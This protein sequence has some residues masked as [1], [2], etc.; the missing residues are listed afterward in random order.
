MLLTT[1]LS[2]D[3]KDSVLQTQTDETKR[4]FLHTGLSKET[5]SALLHSEP[6]SSLQFLVPVHVDGLQLLSTNIPCKSCTR[7]HFCSAVALWVTRCHQR[8]IPASA[9]VP[10]APIPPTKFNISQDCSQTKAARTEGT[11]GP[12][13]PQDSLSPAPETLGLRAFLPMERSCRCCHSLPGSHC[14]NFNSTSKI[15]YMQGLLPHERRGA[16]KQAEV[17]WNGGEPSDLS[18]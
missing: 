4:E 5:L 3:C 2:L 13:P 16:G 18:P 9:H 10:A 17:L 8:V 14:W 11:W 7:A 15:A 1:L 6:S 12:S